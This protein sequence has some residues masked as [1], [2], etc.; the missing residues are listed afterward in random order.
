MKPII[1]ITDQLDA[2]HGGKD[3]LMGKLNTMNNYAKCQ[4]QANGQF[5]QASENL[6]AMGP[7][8]SGGTRGFALDMLQIGRDD[9]R[10]RADCAKLFK[11]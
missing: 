5:Q 8:A 10:Q 1:D 11:F 3:N 4:A 7:A 2:V 6:M 9:Q